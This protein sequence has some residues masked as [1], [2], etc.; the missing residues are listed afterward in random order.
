M[1][2]RAKLSNCPISD[3][4]ARLVADQIRGLSVEKA[5]N[6]LNFSPK[7]AAVLIRK[8]VGSVIANAENNNGLDIDELFISRIFVDQASTFKRF[9][10]CAKGRGTRIVKRNCHITVEVDERVA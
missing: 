2:V 10:A 9:K 8:L 4:K 7:K 5:V 6:L 1:S 3:Q